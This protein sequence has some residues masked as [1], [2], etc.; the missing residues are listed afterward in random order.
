MILPKA[1]QP[2]EPQILKEHD[3]ADTMRDFPSAHD[4]QPSQIPAKFLHRA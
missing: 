4:L 2:L 3:L 1:E